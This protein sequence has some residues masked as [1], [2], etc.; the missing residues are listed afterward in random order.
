MTGAGAAAAGVAATAG[1]GS[2]QPAAADA[3]S[4]AEIKQAKAYCETVLKGVDAVMTPEDPIKEGECGS[5][6][7]YRLSSVSK[8]PAVE[9]SPPVVLTCDMVATLDRW[10][11]RE[12]QPQARA[13]VGGPI[14]KIDTMSSY[15][16]RNAYGRTKTRLSEHAK[17]NAIDIGG[18]ATGKDTVQIL[19][20]WGPTERELRAIAAKREAERAASAAA[21]AGGQS[22][23]KAPLSNL[24]QPVPQAAQ[25]SVGTLTGVPGAVIPGPDSQH[26][27]GLAPTRLGGPAPKDGRQQPLP[28]LPSPPKVN[29][30]KSQFLRNI[31]ASA[32]RYFGTV[33]G[34]EANNAHKNHFHL[35]MAQRNRGSF[36]E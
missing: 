13:L 14:V 3:W 26:S 10:I 12:V 16:C 22:G 18:F 25:P 29:D 19:T 35:D 6:V 15:S 36:C 27:L 9:I 34:P 7:V 5:P 23:A 30:P 28:T 32:C 20:A 21:A 31:H 8:S 24:P 2:N 11:K 4:E 1:S 17:A 33:L